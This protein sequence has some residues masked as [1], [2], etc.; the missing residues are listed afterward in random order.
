M[1]LATSFRRDTIFSNVSKLD[2]C[3]SP[4]MILPALPVAAVETYRLGS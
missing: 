1:A 3:S 4:M 2:V